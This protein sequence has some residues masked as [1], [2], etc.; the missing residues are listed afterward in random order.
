MHRK[1][2]HQCLAILRH[3]IGAEP[4]SWA[5]IV[6]AVSVEMTIRNWMDVRDVLQYALERG[7]IERLPSVQVEQYRR[8]EPPPVRKRRAS[9]AAPGR[10]VALESAMPAATSPVPATRNAD[11]GFFGTMQPHAQ[12]AWPVAIHAIADATDLPW[13]AVRAFL[14]AVPGRH[15]ADAVQDRLALGYSLESAIRAVVQIWMEWRIGYRTSR[16]YGIPRG[17]PYLTGFV[18]HCDHTQDD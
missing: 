10:P 4:V 13:E 7:E 2:Q 11:W 16:D 17:L 1:L 15:F 5:D 12:A 14:D 3:T 9:A 8:T 18:I 6:K